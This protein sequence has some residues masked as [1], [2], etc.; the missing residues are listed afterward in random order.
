VKA[1][2]GARESALFDDGEK[3]FEL[4]QVH[5]SRARCSKLSINLIY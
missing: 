4:R 2:S 1:R 3:G 5:G